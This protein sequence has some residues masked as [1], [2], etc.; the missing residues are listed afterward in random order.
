MKLYVAAL[1]WLLSMSH[2]INKMSNRVFDAFG[3]MK[4]AYVIFKNNAA[5]FLSSLGLILLSL[6]VLS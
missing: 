3:E 5:V 2:E 6:V 4:N 1:N